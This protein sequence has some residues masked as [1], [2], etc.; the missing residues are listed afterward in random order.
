M[1][2]T[3]LSPKE[4][5]L[6]TI[7]DDTEEA[8]W[9]VMGDRQFWAASDLAQA[10]REYARRHALGWYVASMLPIRFT[11][12]R[13]AVKAVLAP[14]LFVAFAGDYPR[15]SFDIEEEGGFPPFILEVLSPESTLRDMELKL[16]AYDSLG[17]REYALYAPTPDLRQPPVQGFRREPASGAFVRWQ[18]DESGRLHSEVLNLWLVPRGPELRLQDPGGAILPTYGELEERTETLK[19]RNEALEVEVARLSDELARR[20]KG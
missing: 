10:L 1:A 5:I 15:Q 17:A 14:D 19:D 16:Q 11:R 18:P 3:A 2:Q 8:S 13:T 6:L 12:P 9:M 7:E 20:L 4:F